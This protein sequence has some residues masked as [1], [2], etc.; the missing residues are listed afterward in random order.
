MAE[1][2]LLSRYQLRASAARRNAD[3]ASGSGGV[4]RAWAWYRLNS[5]TAVFLVARERYEKTDPEE[6][7][8]KLSADLCAALHADLSVFAQ[9]GRLG[10]RFVAEAAG[11][12]VDVVDAD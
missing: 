5:T 9:V 4:Q 1:Y 10:E 12:R 2:V 6:F 8:L 7:Q 3:E 11:E